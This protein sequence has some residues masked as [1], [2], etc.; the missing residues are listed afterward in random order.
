MTELAI[1]GR[2]A[3]LRRCRE[4]A[5]RPGCCG[6]VVVGPAGVGK[7]K[8]ANA[9]ATD[10]CADGREL[11][12]IAGTKAASSIPMGAVASLLAMPSAPTSRADLM[13]HTVAA[14]SARGNGHGLVAMVDDAQWLDDAT[15]TLIHQ[16]ALSTGVFL[17]VT[18]RTSEPVADSITSLWKDGIAERLDLGVLDH[19]TSADLVESILGHAAD[20]PTARA[21]FE[22]SGGNPLFLEQL[23]AGGLDSGALVFQ[24]ADLHA[25]GSWKLVGSLPLSRDLVA[26]VEARVAHL[27]DEDRS[28]IELLALGEPLGA[29][30][31]EALVGA[32]AD[33][34]LARL[35]SE[36]FIVAIQDQRRLDVRL[37]HPLYGEVL[38][39]TMPLSWA[40][41]AR[42][43]LADAVAAHGWRRQNDAIRVAM[44]RLD[45]GAR[46]P[47]E[48]ALAAAR[49]ALLR[50]GSDLAERIILSA[51]GDRSADGGVAEP[52]AL[53]LLATIASRSGRAEEA[54]RHLDE[55]D[56]VLDRQT[57]DGRLRSESAVLRF[58]VLGFQLGRP[59]EAFA[60]SLRSDGDP[61]V[62][63]ALIARKAVL[64]S[65]GGRPAIAASLLADLQPSD[66]ETAEEV[67][68]WF[69]RAMTD[70]C[71][72]RTALALEH[73]DRAT[74]I[75]E[76]LGWSPSMPD[77]T[78]ITIVRI[79]ILQARGEIED[80]MTLAAQAT[81]FERDRWPEQGVSWI[82]CSA[83][84]IMCLQGRV[85][86]ALAAA[87]T[88]ADVWERAEAAPLTD[89]AYSHV[90]AAC[91][92]MG[93]ATG[94]LVAADR[95]DELGLTGYHGKVT[96]A[97][98][99][100]A[101][102]RVADGIGLLIESLARRRRI[103]ARDELHLLI[104]I[105]RLGGAA[106]VVDIAAEFA[107]RCDSD[108]ARLVAAWAAAATQQDGPA[109]EA[110]VGPLASLTYTLAA[111]EAAVAAATAYLRAG[112]PARSRAAMTRAAE[113]QRSLTGIRTPGLHP[114]H[115]QAMLAPREREAAALAATGASGQAIADALGIGV[116]TVESYLRSAYGKLGLTNRA[117][118]T[119]AFGY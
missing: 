1:V 86:A 33:E 49:E 30:L 57:H 73:I 118:L 21:L 79:R 76:R 13:R 37:G 41:R 104:D 72:G 56:D 95:C 52:H 109:L 16:L 42:L 114:P 51:D 27:S 93:D 2:S 88:A 36:G 75:V 54:I 62:E 77:P 28:I 102:G 115:V 4:A 25:A 66:A 117:D 96:R 45:A 113:L 71:L 99:V 19:D 92:A 35:E 15:A 119:D 10:L 103:D 9:F 17:V 105:V 98:A 63:R 44:W 23:V 26:A 111:A 74:A 81:E 40:N 3:E 43:S 110:L 80:A 22:A 31:L 24:E 5:A 78:T 116:R 6:V 29:G 61:A 47:P 67:W 108:V 106:Q 53:M 83:S 97:W 59:V 8:L 14:L 87:A 55:L 69:A 60:L 89:M 90:A 12:R 84:S 85:H 91:A 58:N 65:L 48:I 32:D 68:V 94:A 39:A 100:V 38:R 34:R 46:T 64:A 107:A 82:R 18:V 70:G 7:S 50:F 112:E 20:A 101:A 11:L